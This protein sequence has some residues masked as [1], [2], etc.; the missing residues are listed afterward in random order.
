M[1]ATRGRNPKSAAGRWRQKKA[2]RFGWY[3]GPN[4]T[5]TLPRKIPIPPRPPMETP[6]VMQLSNTPNATTKPT[7]VIHRTHLISTASLRDSQS[8]TPMTAGRLPRR[9]FVTD[10]RAS[11]RPRHPVAVTHGPRHVTRLLRMRVGCHLWP[12]QRAIKA[13]FWPGHLQ[14]SRRRGPA[15]HRQPPANSKQPNP[16]RSKPTQTRAA[17]HGAP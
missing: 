15:S 1:Y 11:R 9:H 12:V 2:G 3:I 10:R 4:W 16:N 8:Y 13:T 17:A 7:I 5:H 6:A 14:P